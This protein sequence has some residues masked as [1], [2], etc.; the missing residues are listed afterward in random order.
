MKRY[1]SVVVLVLAALIVMS[2]LVAVAQE[3]PTFTREQ[4]QA[5]ANA[6][7][8]APKVGDV[9]PLF[10]L[11]LRFNDTSNEKYIDLNDQVG[12]QPIM[13]IFGSYT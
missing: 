12:T 10:K 4:M 9:A 11:D 13:L 7:D 3:Q 8:D 1:S 2:T 5:M 6:K